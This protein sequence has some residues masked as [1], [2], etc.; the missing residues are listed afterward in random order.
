[1]PRVRNL[2]K[3]VMTYPFEVKIL[4][5][6]YLTRQKDEKEIYLARCVAI[7]LKNGEVKNNRNKFKLDI[8]LRK[9]EYT[10]KPIRQNDIIKLSENIYWVPVGECE[11]RF[12]EKSKLATV[13]PKYI[14]KDSNG[15]PYFEEK[16]YPYNV[17]VPCGEWKMFDRYS[18]D[19]FARLGVDLE[20]CI[21]LFFD[22]REE[23]LGFDGGDFY[24]EDE[25]YKVLKD[26]NKMVVRYVPYVHRIKKPEKKFTI[27]IERDEDIHQWI[28]KIKNNSKGEN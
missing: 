28:L 10:E 25:E 27:E 12:Y 13:N 6:S 22:T 11:Y 16:V 15:K 17:S 5:I 20:H 7:E 8:W 14:Q 1:M 24:I 9:S 2:Y 3:K 18:E 21:D 26:Q 19:F 4:S 23:V